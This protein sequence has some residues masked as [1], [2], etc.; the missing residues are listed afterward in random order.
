MIFL[1]DWSCKV[2]FMK[3]LTRWTVAMPACQRR[4]SWLRLVIIQIIFRWEKHKWSC[5]FFL[6][7]NTAGCMNSWL[8]RLSM[9][10]IWYDSATTLGSS[11]QTG[12]RKARRPVSPGRQ[13]KPG[14]RGLCPLQTSVRQTWQTG[15]DS[16]QTCPPPP[17]LSSTWLFGYAEY[18][19][20]HSRQ[21]LDGTRPA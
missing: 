20:I 13:R 1:R 8:S 9:R 21:T 12:D 14:M 6:M 5:F 11:I 19:H 18:T 7:T 10:V 16:Y 17:Q 2:I 15:A 3:G 4:W